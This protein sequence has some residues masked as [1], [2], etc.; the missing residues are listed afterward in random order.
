[1]KR[2]VL[3][4]SFPFIL[5]TLQAQEAGLISAWQFDKI[6][7][8]EKV[9]PLTRRGLPTPEVDRSYFVADDITGTKGQI[10]GVFHK[11]VKGVVGSAVQ[12]DGMSSFMEAALTKG[13]KDNFSVGAWIA[14]GAFPTHWCPV[15]DQNRASNKG[16]FL[17]VNAYGHAGFHVF[18]DGKWI[19]IQSK[20]R[21]ALRQWAHIQGV[22]SNTAGLKLYLNGK[23][24]AEQKTEGK[25]EPSS[26][27]K[28][29]IGKNS[30]LQKPEGTVRQNGTQPIYTFFDGLID[31]LKIYDKALTDNEIELYFNKTKTNTAPE[32]TTRSLPLAGAK[33]GKFGAVYTTL[34]YY[35]S[36]DKL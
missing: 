6:E 22:Y 19:E 8:T 30:I 9:K 20:E 28:L 7:K 12:L 23:L 1:M 5:G 3:I 27:L 31:E 25:F 14:L 24:A 18:V 16:F 34:K 4:F 15:A 32:L 26:N 29:L 21:I 13:I 33:A 17:S 10:L 2:L 11:Q 35:E 36:W